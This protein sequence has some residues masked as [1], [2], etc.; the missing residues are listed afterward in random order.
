MVSIKSIDVELRKIKTIV[1]DND[2]RLMIE[3]TLSFR[4]NYNINMFFKKLD[5]DFSLK[6][7]KDSKDKEK[8][9]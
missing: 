6:S 3:M 4:E 2:D 9:F 5:E 8:L 7:I 1:E